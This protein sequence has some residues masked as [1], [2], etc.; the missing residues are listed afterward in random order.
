[1]RSIREPSFETVRNAS[2]MAGGD[3]DP[4][5]PDPAAEAASSDIDAPVRRVRDTADARLLHAARAGACAS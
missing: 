1:M 5:P 4:L 2:S 3:G